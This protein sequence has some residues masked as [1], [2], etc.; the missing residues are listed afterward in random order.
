MNR[1]A[2]VDDEPLVQPMYYDHPWEKAA[3]EVRNQYMFGSE[4]I[5]APITTPEDP[6]LRLGR[7]KAW[8]PDGTWVD[9]FTGLVYRGGRSAYLH[10]DLGSIPVLARAGAIVP[11]VPESAVT[12]ETANPDALELRVFAGADGS[13][14]L[15]EDDDD[16]RWASTTIRLDFAAGEVTID[17]PGGELSSLP[18]TRSYDIVLVGFA[19]VDSVD[20]VTAG[21]T[22][23]LPVGPGPVPGSVLV[24]LGPKSIGEPVRL[25][26]GGDS[27]LARNAVEDRLFALLDRANIAFDLK[28]AIWDAVRREDVAS[29]VLSLQGLDLSPELLGAVSELLLAQ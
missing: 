4:L 24:R 10:R 12:N 7:V 27:T 16:E 25:L 19:A 14:T 11:L 8:I 9:F 29:A 21:G 6:A 5:V 1:R 28:G 18:Q 15:W 2:H 20:A 22:Q 3:Y 13:F 17:E 26:L 23:R